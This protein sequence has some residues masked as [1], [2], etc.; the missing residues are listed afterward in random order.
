M[1]V[2]QYV[3]MELER[4]R[5]GSMIRVTEKGLPFNSVNHARTFTVEQYGGSFEIRFNGILYHPDRTTHELV[6]YG[7]YGPFEGMKGALWE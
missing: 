6:P 5:N 1:V 3:F 4:F 2:R 7:E